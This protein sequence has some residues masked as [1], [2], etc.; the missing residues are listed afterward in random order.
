MIGTVTSAV[1]T[2]LIV[3][4]FSLFLLGGFYALS[5]SGTPSITTTESYATDIQERA[6]LGMVK[7]QLQV[8]ILGIAL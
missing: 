7:K 2:K 8:F 6:T 3:A 4:L 5:S 1:R